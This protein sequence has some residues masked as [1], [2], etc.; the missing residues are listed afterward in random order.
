M[1]IKYIIPLLAMIFHIPFNANSNK[2]ISV[3]LK[4]ILRSEEQGK[5]IN[6]FFV[7]D[8]VLKIGKINHLPQSH[9]ICILLVTAYSRK[10]TWKEKENS[11]EL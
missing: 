2:D 3:A 1:F 7:G 10:Y 6:S 11:I 5:T 4:M 8:R 9:V